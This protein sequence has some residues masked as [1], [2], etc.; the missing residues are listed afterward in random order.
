MCR[1]NLS[2]DID[3]ALKNYLKSQEAENIALA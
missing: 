1:N 2:K 3:M